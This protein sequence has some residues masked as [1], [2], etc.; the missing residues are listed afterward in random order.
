MHDKDKERA[1]PPDRLQEQADVADA[2]RVPMPYR[3]L[4]PNSSAGSSR[5]RRSDPLADPEAGE[6]ALDIGDAAD[7]VAVHTVGGAEGVVGRWQTPAGRF[8]RTALALAAFFLIAGFIWETLKWFGGT[9]WRFD[10]LLGSGIDYFHDPPF[11]VLQF[12]DRQLPHIW[13]ILFELFEPFRRGSDQTLLE[14]LLGAALFTMRQ[15]FIGFVLGALIGIGIA[16]IFVHS[17]RSERTFMPYVVASQ[18]IPIV[19]LAPVI[20]LAV[21]LGPTAVVIVATYLTFFP[22]T[23][24]QLRGLRSPDPRAMELMRSYGASRWDVYR[25]LRFPA[26]VPFLFTALKVAATWAI[27]GAIIGEGPGGVGEGLGKAIISFSQQYITGPE[28]L[29]ATILIASLVGIV[30]YLA[31]RAAEVLVLRNRPGANP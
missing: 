3:A 13:D 28:K 11:R 14:F 5:D 30:A 24:S 2:G 4:G 12:S 27:I 9:P 17:V 7:D 6:I 15:A 10:N 21:G 25:K 19:A 18:T 26:S 29:W 23:I 1:T 8:A 22:V 31:V 20:A 16:S